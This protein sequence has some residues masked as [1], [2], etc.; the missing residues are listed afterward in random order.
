M[1]SLLTLILIV[2]IGYM[3]LPKII[4]KLNKNVKNVSGKEAA[5]LIRNNKNLIILDV[6]KVR[7]NTNQV[8]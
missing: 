7:V 6:R 5:S 1:D 2:A 4:I 8:I 3:L